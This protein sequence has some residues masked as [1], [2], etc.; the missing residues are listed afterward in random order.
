M[1]K[2]IGGLQGGGDPMGK[3]GVI[4]G[5]RGSYS[6]KGGRWVEGII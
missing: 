1:A 4:L 6:G 5:V 2:K 3:G